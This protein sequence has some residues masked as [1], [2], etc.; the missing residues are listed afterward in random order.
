M[1]VVTAT[2]R[3]GKDPELK[4]SENGGENLV[5]SLAVDTGKNETTW[6][7]VY[8]RNNTPLGSFVSNHVKKGKALMV[9][10]TLLVNPYT[11][12]DGSPKV[13]LKLMGS[14]IGFVPSSQKRE[15]E[16]GNE[17]NTDNTDDIPF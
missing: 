2:G 8:V 1:I 6:F 14:S 11:G 13:S 9:S 17:D 3:V 7:N 10:G 16:G 12:S 5:F 4:I 15:G